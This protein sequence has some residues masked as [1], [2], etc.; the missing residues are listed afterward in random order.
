MESNSSII[1][2]RRRTT[3]DETETSPVNKRAR[4]FDGE[5]IAEQLKRL[6]TDIANIADETRDTTTVMND[7]FM[8]LQEDF[9]IAFAD[10]FNKAKAEIE[11]K[12]QQRETSEAMA[13]QQ[14]EELVQLARD[15]KRTFFKDMQQITDRMTTE[16]T[17]GQQALMYTEIMTKIT[18]ALE[19]AHTE[20][21]PTEPDHIARL[22]ELSSVM[23]SYAVQQLSVTLSNIY[24]KG[25]DIIVKSSAMLIAS[26]MLYN[27]IPVGARIPLEG[28]PYFGDLFRL[29]NMAN[30][31]LLMIQN[32]A[33]TVTTIFYLLK[34]MGIDTS[35]SL[36]Q[37]GTMTRETANICSKTTGKYVCS[38]TGNMVS[39]L[40]NGAKIVSDFI[41]DK[42]GNILTSEYNRDILITDSQE[43]VETSIT[44]M[45]QSNRS[46]SSLKS[47]SSLLDTN[48]DKG[49]IDI[50]GVAIPSNVVE[51]RFDAI[52]TGDQSNPV[53]ANEIEV[54]NAP[55]PV[56]EV[57]QYFNSQESN[58][59]ELTE[60]S[61]SEGWL[62][63][64]YRNNSIGGKKMRKSKRAM[65]KIRS[66]RKKNGRKRHTTKKGRKHYKTLKYRSKKRY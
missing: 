41:I 23:V 9:N 61:N 43:S 66:R 59:S 3:P 62:Y 30:P 54:A 60:G 52:V 46:L 8:K 63:W 33:A 1:G 38:V 64:L 14:Q 51:E 58:M 21:Q 27:Y 31:E 6:G 56:A 19:M 13:M 36:Q 7:A 34:N 35:E 65:K 44:N 40:Q 45:S 2:K 32:S 50:A 37:L 28:I 5:Q 29:I 57:E 26:G 25:P 53:I 48:I 16:L 24:A 39:G 4:A 47:I 20:T 42:L 18:K 17:I 55:V 49:G 12:R 22:S 15:L 10:A 11:L